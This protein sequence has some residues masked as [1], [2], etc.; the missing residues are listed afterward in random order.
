MKE[1]CLNPKSTMYPV[2]GGNGITVCDKWRFS[3]E[4]FF[5]DM[6]KKPDPKFYL[7]RI[8]NLRGYEPSNCRWVSASESNRNRRRWKKTIA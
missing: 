3:F 5:S 7:D 2:Y 6:G 4:N 8:D 1:R